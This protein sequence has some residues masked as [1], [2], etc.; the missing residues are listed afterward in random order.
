[1]RLLPTAFTL[2]LVTCHA[3]AQ[4]AG[5]AAA[6]AS[7][8]AIM[9]NQQ[10]NDTAMQAM[11]N[12]QMQQD[13]AIPQPYY[14]IA[15]KPK[16][17]VKPGTYSS[18]TTVKLTDST[19]GA[20]IYYSTDGW[21]PTAAS[22]RYLGPITIDS[23]TTLQAVA[24]APNLARSFVAV[25]QYSV[26]S[27]SP[28]NAAQQTA[29]SPSAVPPDGK[30]FLAKGSPVPLL[31]GADVSSRTA[32]VGDQLPMTLAE[33]LKI[34]DVVLV[35]KGTP[36]LATVIQVDRNSVFGLPGVLS[37]HVDYLNLD[38]R[39]IRLCG[40]AAREGEAKLPNAAV[41]I[42]VVGPLTAL[43]HGTDAIIKQGTPF[44]ASLF[45]DTFFNPTH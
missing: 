2:L 7:Q 20:I 24:I 23:T 45:A 28:P 37:F 36:A 14:G 13:S 9:A 31:F 39:F 18:P 8:Q 11:R 38:G 22:K 25:A 44:T 27:S 3:Q 10:A 5:A 26:S 33:D 12:A 43:K 19:R 21:T 34:D 32:S 42:P 6:Q 4:D 17:S 1:M 29:E 35:K 15:A 41:L 30:L 40:T 16:F